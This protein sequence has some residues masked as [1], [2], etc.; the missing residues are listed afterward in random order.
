MKPIVIFGI[1]DIAQIMHFYLVNDSPYKVAAFTVDEAYFD[2]NKFCDLPVV[3]FSEVEKLYPPEKFDML[4]AVSYAKCNSV[5]A[6]KFSEAKNKSYKLI[7]YISSKAALWP[8]LDIGE[9]CIILENNTI[10]PFVKIE[11]NVFIWSG[12][13][14]GHHV[15]I[16]DNCFIS[17]H[18]VISGGVRV[19]QSCF[20]GVNATIRDHITI[21][22]NCIIGAG[23]LILEDTQENS[24]YKASPAMRSSVPADRI[25]NI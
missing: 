17:S 13:H 15:R 14:I 24:V 7:N 12:N 3:S 25:K 18:V 6:K 1:G 20:I 10:Q 16:E 4:I 2:K 5:R 22:E 9:N 21:A 23:A 8:G 11:D 19:K